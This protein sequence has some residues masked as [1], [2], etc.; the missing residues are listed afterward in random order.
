[1][2]AELINNVWPRQRELMKIDGCPQPDGSKW[3]RA[4]IVLC[5]CPYKLVYNG[6]EVAGIRINKAVAS[7]LLRVLNAIWNDCECSQAIIEAKHYHLFSGSY[8]Y[9]TIRGKK[10]FSTHAYGRGVDFDAEHNQFHSKKHLFQNGDI[11]VR[12]FKAEGWIWG[13]DWS[14][15]SVDAMHFQAARVR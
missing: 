2:S 8:V 6:H 7:S 4:N 12:N 15:A 11:I 3:A 14:G 1:M 9:R 13:G 10:S 5:K